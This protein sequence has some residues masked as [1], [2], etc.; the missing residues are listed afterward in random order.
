MTDCGS[1]NYAQKWAYAMTFFS[2]LTIQLSSLGM[3]RIQRKFRFLFSPSFS[4]LCTFTPNGRRKFVPRDQVFPLFSIYS[5]LLLHK[6][7]C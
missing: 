4:L 5:L 6:N 7:I 1:S 3:Y 2:G